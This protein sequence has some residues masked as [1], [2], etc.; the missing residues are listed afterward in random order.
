MKSLCK[1]S[2]FQIKRPNELY[3]AHFKLQP[4]AIND[5]KNYGYKRL[6]VEIYYARKFKFKVLTLF[7]HG[8]YQI[9]EDY[10]GYIVWGKYGFRMTEADE[11]RY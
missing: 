8:N 1:Y 11:F 3:N 4:H 2:M 7:A 5:G 9:K 10:T 6:Q